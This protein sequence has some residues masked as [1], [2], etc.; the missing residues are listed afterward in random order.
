MKLENAA[1]ASSIS[2]SWAALNTPSTNP[3]EGASSIVNAW[4]PSGHSPP[5]VIALN[6]TAV[7]IP[8][9]AIS[10]PF[11]RGIHTREFRAALHALDARALTLAAVATILN[12]AVMGFYDVLAF[13]HTRTRP[14]ERWRFGAV[15]FCWSNFLTLGPLAGPAIRLWLYRRRVD[16]LAE[17]HAGIVSVVIAFASGLAGWTLAA[18]LVA[19]AGGGL[20]ALAATA[21]LLVIGAAWTGRANKPIRPSSAVSPT[22]STWPRK[23]RSPWPATTRPR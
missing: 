15:A 8:L 6:P 12:V 17:L 5:S 2:N 21:L 19:R 3:T 11:M 13:R 9:I 10:A 1:P 20:L 14:I 22:P 16:D 23:T 4:A 7:S 18:L